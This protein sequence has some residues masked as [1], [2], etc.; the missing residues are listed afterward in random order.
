[1][2]R[3]VFRLTRTA[4]TPSALTPVQL[5]NTRTQTHTSRASTIAHPT[6]PRTVPAPTSRLQV[7]SSRH[8]HT[9]PRP[10]PATSLRRMPPVVAHTRPT[11]LTLLLLPL[12]P[13]TRTT[14]DSPATLPT[15]ART[16][17]LTWAVKWA[18][19][20]TSPPVLTLQH[21][22][23]NSI[24]SSSLNINKWVTEVATPCGTAATPGTP[25]CSSNSGIR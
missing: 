16:W 5:S 19:R 12:I 10:P 14:T 21:H 3:E 2:R 1:M 4:T 6:M 13:G 22:K 11:R 9:P 18:A 23:P 7:I 24:S 17:T 20:P 15:Q 25:E 8:N